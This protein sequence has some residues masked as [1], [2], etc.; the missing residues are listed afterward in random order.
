LSGLLW[1]SKWP[2]LLETIAG[3][4]LSLWP[5]W[6]A[7]YRIRCSAAGSPV[8]TTKNFYNSVCVDCFYYHKVQ[9]LL[10]LTQNAVRYDIVCSLRLV[11]KPKCLVNRILRF[12]IHACS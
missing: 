8:L 10:I 3:P 2:C 11:S 1:R 12:R 9:N 6:I 4:F 5:W 7:Y